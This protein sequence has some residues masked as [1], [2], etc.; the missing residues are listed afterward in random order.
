MG[1]VRKVRQKNNS[2]EGRKRLI[3]WNIAGVKSKD[4]EVWRF[5]EKGDFISLCE[6]WLEE[7]DCKSWENKLS[8]K[9]VWKAIP[10]RRGAKRGRAKGGFLIGIRKEWEAGIRL[11]IKEVEEGLVKTSIKGGKERLVIWSV[12]NSG[13]IQKFYEHWNMVDLTEE[14]KVIVGGDFNIRIG[15]LGRLVGSTED[16]TWELE[17]RESKDKT[18]SNGCSELLEFCGDRDWSIANGNF[19]GDERGEFTYIGARGS[20]VIDLVIIN[21]EVRESMYKFEVGERIESDH[22]PVTVEIMGEERSLEGSKECVEKVQTRQRLCWGEEAISVFR[23]R[24]EVVEKE[25]K[26]EDSVEEVWEVTKKIVEDAVTRKEFK[27]KKW[28]V[29]TRKW[30]DRDCAKVKRRA[31]ESYKNW[32]KGKV[33]K[34]RYLEERNIWRRTCREKEREWKDAEVEK[35]RQIKNESEVWNFLNSHRKRRERVENNIDSEEWKRHFVKLLEGSEERTMGEI[36]QEC[37]E[38]AEKE[39]EKI[40]VREIKEAWK[41][42]KKKKAAGLDGIPNEVWIH[43]GEGLR[44]ILICVLGK[45]WDGQGLPR[46]WRAG[47]IVPL[48]KKGNPEE[49]KNYRGITLM[50]TAYKLY[51]ELI[52]KRLEKEVE[53]L[54]VLP[55]GQAG[56]RKGR[57]TMDNIYVLDHLIN[58]AKKSKEQLYS[59]FVDL[60]AAFDTVDRSKLWGILEKM[61]ISKYLI[62]RIKELYQE[63]MVKVR[64]GEHMTEEFWTVKGLKQGCVLSPLLFSLYIAGLE[65]EMRGRNVGGVK[66]GKVR[67]WVLAYADDLILLA[68]NR[69]AMLQMLRILKIFLDS[70]GL[71]LSEEKTKILVFNRGRRSKKERWW[72]EGNELE[73]VKVFKYL[74][75]IFNSEGNYKDQLAELKKKGIAAAKKT[76]GLGENTGKNDFNRREMLFDYL[77]RSVMAYGCEIW[78]WRE[79]KEL[80]KVQLDYFRWVLRLDFCTPRHLIYAE[81]KIEKLKI[82]WGGRAI[83]FEE[84][85]SKLGE[86]RLTKMCWLEKREGEAKSGYCK[87]RKNYLNNLGFSELEIVNMRNREEQIE[88]ILVRRDRDI[89]KQLIEGK[90]REAKYNRRFGEI[91]TS[92]RPSYLRAYK[93]DIDIDIVAKIRCGNFENINKYWLSEEERRCRLC[94]KEGESLEHLIGRCEETKEWMCDLKKEGMF[95]WKD[96]MSEESSIVIVKA[97]KKIIAKQK[98]I[99]RERTG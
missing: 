71:I 50:A 45:V 10:A 83:R 25:V 47:V 79:R 26:E 6:T 80:E 4:K 59:V 3:F 30:W 57:S 96:Y 48:F 23:N 34:E 77:V 31:W 46:E 68:K 5:L 78:G 33:N 1:D 84:K 76:W 39:K 70:R 85:V 18:C 99:E 65:E 98:R 41:M 87:D 32:K 44:N 40:T 94:K 12:Y 56:F 95:R 19:Y 92:K 90:I 28:A 20:S 67:V 86:E 72:W 43:G 14:G 75:F 73:E 7:K 89:E 35:L 64:V 11:E 74:G 55:E 66:I 62:E 91:L 8:K 27:V 81:T 16:N 63:T 13:N 49:A 17:K 82:G 21:D 42:L 61:G 38:I 9:F 97:F 93:R 60:K 69:E 54:R 58:R 36:R 29:G 24:T 15:N 52:R 53:E 22:T 88:E 37:E 51:T 2:N